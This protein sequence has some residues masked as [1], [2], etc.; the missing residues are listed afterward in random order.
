M[1]TPANVPMDW[2]VLNVTE[3]TIAFI[4]LV[5]SMVIVTTQI[6]GLHALVKT[7]G[8]E[9]IV[10]W[11]I[12]AIIIH[13]DNTEGVLTLIKTILVFVTRNTQVLIAMFMIFVLGNRAKIME[14]V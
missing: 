9:K 13:V 14:H 3:L 7:I 5:E 8:W 12:T 2:L 6:L 11:P 10:P 1:G 4:I